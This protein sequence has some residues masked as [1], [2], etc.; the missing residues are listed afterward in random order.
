MTVLV[1]YGFLPVLTADLFGGNFLGHRDSVVPEAGFARLAEDLN[2]TFLRFPGGSVT[3]TYYAIADPDRESLT[4]P[5]TGA[6]VTITPFSDFMGFAAA[7]G[8]P[9]TITLPTRGALTDDRDANGDRFAAIDAPLLRQFVTDAV[10]GV[11]GAAQIAAFEIGNEYWGSGQMSAVE[12]GRVSSEMAHLLR[13]I[14]DGLADT[15]G[16]RPEIHVQMGTNFNF[17]S[18]DER[19]SGTTDEIL[20]ALSGEYGLAFTQEVVRNSGE[21]DWTRVNNQLLLSAYDTADEIAAVDGVIVHLFSRDPALPGQR[22]FQLGVVQE[23]WVESGRFDD[24]SIYV[25]EWNQSGSSAEFDR[26]V[27]YG[28]YQAQE[29]LEILEAFSFWGVDRAAVWPLIQNTANALAKGASYDGLTPAGEVFRLM[30]EVLPGLAPIDFDPGDRI[31]TELQIGDL[32]LHGFHGEERIEIFV[33]SRAEGAVRTEIDLSPLIRAAGLPEAVRV[34]VLPGQA[35]GDKAST[36]VL[37]P[38]S[39]GELLN[40]THLRVSLSPGEILHVRFDDFVP[41]QGFHDRA[42]AHGLDTGRPLVTGTSGDDRIDVEAGSRVDGGDGVDT[43]VLTG[44]PESYTLGFA[45]DSIRLQDRSQ[46][47]EAQITLHDVEWIVFSDVLPQL[48]S[49]R[50]PVDR[51]D[52]LSALRPEDIAAITELYIAYFD[53]APDALGLHFWATAFSDGLGF[54]AIAAAFFDQPE[55]RSLYGEVTD[56]SAYVTAVY[57]NVLGRA[58]DVAGLAFWQGYL[59][60]DPSAHIPIFIEAVLAGAKA[61]SG[62][63][64]DAAYLAGKTTLGTYFAVTTGLSDLSAAQDVMRIY[65]ETEGDLTRA[66]DAV[67]RASAEMRAGDEGGFLIQTLGVIDWGEIF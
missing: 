67:D 51:F 19:Y 50:F 35:P 26:R 39:R 28:L 18:L 14:L 16:P 49:A 46:T 2:I 55:H 66:V 54:D 30:S 27:D 25:S 8:L 1:P 45:G 9:V 59:E 12:Y 37:T 44:A 13:D 43:V 31:E 3:E 52:G 38:G 21:I 48:G 10:S 60:D 22:D 64:E 34:G 23:M 62:S 5:A 15:Y 7:E 47:A 40:E 58:P 41:T 32:S 65:E 4:D 61:A 42:V 56:I 17:S 57:E 53:R 24:L 33:G 63:P 6:P 11:F 20:A 29:M 36:A